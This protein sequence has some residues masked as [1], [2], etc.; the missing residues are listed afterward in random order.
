MSKTD[1]LHTLQKEITALDYNKMNNFIRKH[2][3]KDKK[4]HV[5]FPCK[6]QIKNLLEDGMSKRDIHRM[7]EKEIPELEHH[8]VNN[9]T[10][11]YFKKDKKENK[12]KL[13]IPYKDQIKKFLEDE[14]SKTSILHTL[15]KEISGLDYD[16]VNNF[17][18]RNLKINNHRTPKSESAS[19]SSS[20]SSYSSK[21]SSE[22]STCSNESA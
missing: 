22:S 11:K 4:D 7:L 17:I 9:F 3:K 8:T 14:M 13:I 19:S 21:S 6:D 16:A 20:S 1:I 2:F 12:D 10:N 18:V 15:Q 5:H